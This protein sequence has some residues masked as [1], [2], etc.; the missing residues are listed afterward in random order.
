MICDVKN[1]RVWLFIILLVVM[2][3]FFTVV[4]PLYIYD[5]DDWTYA[6]YSRT[7]LPTL[8]EWNPTKVLPETFMP[9]V[10]KIGLKIIFPFTNNYIESL[11][12]AYGITIA[13]LISCYFVFACK[14]KSKANYASI[15]G[16][17][18][19]ILLHF[20]MYI[21]SESN[22]KFFFYGGNVTCYFNYIVPAILNFFVVLFLDNQDDYLTNMTKNLKSTRQYVQ[23]V[24]L[25]LL[26]YFS[27]FSNLFHNIV[28]VAYILCEIFFSFIRLGFTHQNNKKKMMVNI[29]IKSNLSRFFILFIWF[30]CLI[31]ESQGARAQWASGTTLSNLP[32]NTTFKIFINSIESLN[33]LFIVCVLCLN[34]IAIILCIF[35]TRNKICLDS[36]IFI[37]KWLRYAFSF[38]V[39]TTYLILLCSKVNPNYIANNTVMISWIF[40]CMQ[41]TLNSVNFICSISKVRA[42]M[43]IIASILFYI[44]VING[45]TFADNNV[46]WNYGINTVKILDNYYIKTII[47]ADR[48]NLDK[49]RLF[50]PKC[51]SLQWPLDVGYAGERISKTLY[52]HRIITKNIHV[53]IEQNSLVNHRYNVPLQTMP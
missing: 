9:L 39:T 34:C 33:S 20:L 40:W 17:I 28:L 49:V 32:I 29:F 31:F 46:V 21:N 27:I 45:K 16:V 11:A 24:G 53:V 8:K 30:L 7:F 38:F 50:V 1:K 47:E 44:T 51:K 41:F 18:A 42:C 22:N 3:Y 13:I 48:N 4:H 12:F 6:S 35:M 36:S 37:S 23:M 15:S 43:P 52:K 19:F 26:I 25:F 14:I 2:I 10:S 5:S